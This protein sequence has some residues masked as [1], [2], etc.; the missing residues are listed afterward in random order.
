MTHRVVMIAFENCT[1]TGVTGPM[2]LFGVANMI[3]RRINGSEEPLFDLLVCS[4]TGLP[5]TSSSGFPIPV[6]GDL[7]EV[8]E[9]DIVYFPAG[10]AANSHELKPII[11]SWQGLIAWLKNNHHK[12]DLVATHCSGSFLLAEAGVLDRQVATTAWW[13]TDSMKKNYPRLTVDADAGCTQAGKFLCG[14][15][16]FSFQD[17]S[18]AIIE[19]YA[20]NHFARLVAKYMMLD[21]Q[22]QSQAPYAILTLF[23]SSDPLVNKAEQWIR[24]NLSRDF[25]IDEVAS[26]VAVSPR[27]LIRRFQKSLGESPQ[28]FTQ[29]LRIEKCK[30]LL[31]TTKM[32]FSEIVIRCGYSDDSAFRRL[33]K[34]LCDLSP[35][36]YRKRFAKAA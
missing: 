21:N 12:L 5:V 13:L 9:G 28:S 6:S 25:R 10:M 14:A 29:K 15:A 4:E 7:S 1:T 23:E 27:T 18:L 34:R 26:E 32:S 35:R 2:D 30:A 36:E 31:E 8:R 17:V 11:G 3:S 19:K 22:R 16:S 20:G 24:A 33:F